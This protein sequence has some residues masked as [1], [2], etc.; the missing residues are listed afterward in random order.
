MDSVLQIP[1]PVIMGAKRPDIRLQLTDQ[2]QQYYCI[3]NRN[4]FVAPSHL[5]QD[6]TYP[7]SSFLLRRERPFRMS[8]NERIPLCEDCAYEP[9]PMIV[10]QSRRKTAKRE[11]GPSG[12]EVLTLSSDVD[13]WDRP[14]LD[15][16]AAVRS[17]LELCQTDIE[18]KF[19]RLYYEMALGRWADRGDGWLMWENLLESRIP[20]LNDWFDRQKNLPPP[21]RDPRHVSLAILRGL[22]APVLLPQVW[23]NYEFG[24]E[25]RA[26]DPKLPGRIDFA[27]FWRGEKHAVEI[28]GPSHYARWNESTR[29]YE[30]DEET[31]TATLEKTRN[32]RKLGWQVHRFSNLEVERA[33]VKQLRPGITDATSFDKFLSDLAFEFF[34][35]DVRNYPQ[36][37]CD[38]LPP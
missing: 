3:N 22:T 4:L 15:A 34:G 2:G 7:L 5:D 18:R 12:Y 29:R 13:L 23:I 8:E 19:L 9:C 30:V 25:K 10:K 36:S 26:Y 24:T 11:S 37:S 21:Y 20:D 16:C 14:N 17:L 33:E 31:Y 1:N 38:L 28:D 27:F 6:G 35:G 32:L